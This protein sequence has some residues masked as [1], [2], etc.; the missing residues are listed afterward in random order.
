MGDDVSI[1]LLLGGLG[2]MKAPVP[3]FIDN[4]VGIVSGIAE[5]EAE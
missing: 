2:W 3:G 5:F 4:A 1:A